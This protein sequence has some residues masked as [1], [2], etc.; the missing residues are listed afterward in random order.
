MAF[1]ENPLIV[2]T[3]PSFALADLRKMGR[4]EIN[5]R[6]PVTALLDAES[7]VKR[8]LQAGVLIAAGT[9][10]PYPGD[11]QGEGIHRE[12]ELLVECGLT[13]LGAITIATKNAATIINA[14]A[15]WGTLE[16]GKYADIVIVEGR[17]DQNISET[18]KIAAVVKE[19][20]ILDRNNLKLDPA[21]DPG[22][23]PVGGIAAP[24]KE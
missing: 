7:N 13:P 20:T 12:L 14:E 2:D 23:L 11:F 9:D 4:K 10:A 8:L 19:G 15:Q 16:V 17:P 1:L 3:T 24:G 21:V 22:Y 5:N 6:P 18:R